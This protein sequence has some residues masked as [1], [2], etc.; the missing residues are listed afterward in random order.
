MKTR[1]G[2]LSKSGQLTL[3]L[4][5]IQTPAVCIEYVIMHEICHLFHQNHSAAFYQLLDSV[6]P[7]WIK[8][9]HKLE[10]TLI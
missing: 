5:L 2:S 10:M 4:C 1:W 6:M 7:D 8:R 9:K 3:N